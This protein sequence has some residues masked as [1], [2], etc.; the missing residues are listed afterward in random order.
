MGFLGTSTKVQDMLS[1]ME[2][3]INHFLHIR[4]TDFIRGYFSI[5]IP[6]VLI[7]FLIWVALRASIRT[8]VTQG[9]LRSVAGLITIFAPPAYWFQFWEWTFRPEGWP[10]FGAPFELAIAVVITV[11]FLSRKWSPPFWV[12][13]LLVGAHY[14]YWYYTTEWVPFATNYASPAGAILGFCSAVA[15]VRY[16]GWLRRFATVEAPLAS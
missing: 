7:A 4:Q 8:R 6:S 1:Q 9:F 14:A 5:W 3:R 16:V 2:I 13:L 15:W 10:N 12:G 11:L